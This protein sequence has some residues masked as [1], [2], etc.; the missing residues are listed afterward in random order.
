VNVDAN[1]STQNGAAEK[2]GKI[3]IEM[4]GGIFAVIAS[5]CRKIVV[6]CPL[7]L[8]ILPPKSDGR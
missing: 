4:A 1:H 7:A 2:L 8:P 5:P 6:I 3:C